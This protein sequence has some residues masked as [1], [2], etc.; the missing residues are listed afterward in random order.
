MA[1]SRPTL[2]VRY[3]LWPLALFRILFGLLYLQMALSK[4]PWKFQD[5][6]RYGWLHGWIENEIAHPTFGWYVAFL[7]G[8]VLP[9][10]TFFG[11]MT[12]VTEVALGL[13]FLLGL[14]VP[15]AGI[16]GALWQVN[17]A[18]GSYNVPGEWGWVWMLL[19]APQIVFAL[20]RAGRS[21]GLDARVAGALADRF[22]AGK[23]LPGWARYLA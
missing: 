17:I 8:A 9:Y 2:D 20:C 3:P 14:F 7:K 5:G 19:I 16:A 23:T 4:A 18:L 13:A 1:S 6:F 12:Y 15:V 11:A 22:A 10:F 21:L